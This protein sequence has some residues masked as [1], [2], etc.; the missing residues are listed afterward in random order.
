MNEPL[1]FSINRSVVSLDR[2][3]AAAVVPGT[4]AGPFDQPG[5]F[6]AKGAALTIK[7][8]HRLGR[9]RRRDGTLFAKLGLSGAVLI[10]DI[11]KS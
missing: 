8:P 9:E 7:I 10:A 6:G 5:A 11:R 3:A 2:L 4:I 1:S